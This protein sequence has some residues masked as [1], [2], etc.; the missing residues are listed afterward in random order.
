VNPEFL[1][2]ED[3]LEIHDIQLANTGG[4][5][6]VRD[7]NMLDSAVA[8]AQA[9]FGGQYLHEDLCAM[10]AALLFSLA[11]NHPFLDGNKRTALA[12]ALTFLE[13]NGIVVTHDPDDL[14]NAVMGVAEG[15]F[16]KE[17]VAK[18]FRWLATGEM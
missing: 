14:F 1:T 7:A 9:A 12:A 17:D 4:L 10:A 11:M 13:I 8:Q 18:L 6:G 2:V 5:A 16:S 15:T 3:V